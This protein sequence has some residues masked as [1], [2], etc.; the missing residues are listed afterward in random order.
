[1]LGFWRFRRQTKREF[2][3]GHAK[4]RAPMPKPP[5]RL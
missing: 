1:M 4:Q 5:P 3:E 2:D